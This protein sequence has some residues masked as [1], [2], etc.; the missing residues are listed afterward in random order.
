MPNLPDYD[1]KFDHP[2][3]AGITVTMGRLTIAESFEFEDIIT[4][5]TNTREE[6]LAYSTAL[7]KFVG[8]HT[9]AW[10]LTDREGTALPVGEV[11]DGLL[12]RYIRDGWLEGLNGGD[13]PSPLAAAGPD[14]EFEAEI[15]VEP[16]PG[17]SG[18]ESETTG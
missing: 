3:L 16:L 1:L 13:A 18:A 10:N 2:Q 8:E 6:R 4:M 14:D 17:P 9:I 5:P 11:T 7:A 12:L 15:P